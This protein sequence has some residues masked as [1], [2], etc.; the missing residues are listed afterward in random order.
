MNTFASW[1]QR[2]TERKAKIMAKAHSDSIDRQL[3]EESKNFR[4]QH[5]VLLISSCSRLST[6]VTVYT[7]LVQTG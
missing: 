1:K 7:Q 4:R 3:E 6:L 2:R 5:N